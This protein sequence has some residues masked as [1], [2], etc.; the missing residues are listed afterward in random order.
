MPRR[1]P[2]G[3]PR[4]F[5][6]PLGPVVLGP[7]VLGS[8]VLGFWGP[9]P[10]GSGSWVLGPWGPVSWVLGWCPGF[11]GPGSGSWV[12]VSLRCLAWLVGL[13]G[14]AARLGLGIP[15]QRP[16]GPGQL[17]PQTPRPDPKSR[18]QPSLACFAHCVRLKS[19]ARARSLLSSLF[20]FVAPCALSH[21]AKPV[22]H[23]RTRDD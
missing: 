5:P 11:C 4:T 18:N 21:H 16:G 6:I 12:P 9:L 8:W 14:L 3:S 10:L 13:A 23:T 20:A 1:A 7:G 2:P 17:L 19:C 22:D 15:G